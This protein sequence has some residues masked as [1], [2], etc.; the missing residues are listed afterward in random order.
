MG[1][2]GSA[3]FVNI[4]TPDHAG[5][6]AD[7]RNLSIRVPHKSS[8]AR[9]LQYT[10]W[11]TF[12]NC[13]GD[14]E[15]VQRFCMKFKGRTLD[16][17]ELVRNIDPRN[18]QVLTLSME[19]CVQYTGSAL[20]L[21]YDSTQDFSVT[22]LEL[23]IIGLPSG[24]TL[25]HLKQRVPWTS[26][27]AQI[28]ETA[29]LILRSHQTSDSNNTSPDQQLP[30]QNIIGITTDDG[31]SCER[32]FLAIDNSNCNMKL[33][34]F[35]GVDYAPDVKSN[36]RLVLQVQQ[37]SA[38]EDNVTI[39]FL[40]DAQLTMDTM[41]I[42]N[43]TKVQDLKDFIC[44]VYGHT[45]RLA[46]ED[47]KLIYKGHLLHENTLSGDP[48]KAL[49][50]LNERGEV[51]IHV[52][53]NEEYTE[54][55]PGFWNEL[56]SSRDRFSF[57][58]RTVRNERA[59][60]SSIPLQERQD[61]RFSEADAI[62]SSSPQEF[63]TQTGAE[64][65]RTGQFFEKVSIS[66]HESFVQ[67]GFFEPTQTFIELE[68]QKLQLYPEEFVELRGA[69]LLSHRALQRISSNFGIEIQYSEGAESVPAAVT[70][71]AFQNIRATDQLNPV[72][73]EELEEAGRV[74]RLRQWIQTIMRTIYLI[75]RNSVFFFFVFFQFISVLKTR[76]L[77]LGTVLIIMKAIWSTPEIG[78]M[79]RELLSGEEESEISDEELELVTK[80]YTDR[81]LTRAF[82]H[83]FASA[84]PVVGALCRHLSADNQLKVNL[85]N[86]FKLDHT[87]ASILFLARLLEE[88]TSTQHDELDMSNLHE[89]FEPLV[90][91]AVEHAQ[92]P[93]VLDAASKE[94]LK[95]LRKFAYQ[96]S[97]LPWHKNLF[98]LFSSMMDY[99]YNGGLIRRLI[100]VAERRVR[101][102]RLVQR[103]VGDVV[104]LAVL[105]VL[106]LVPRF[107]RQAVLEASL[108]STARSHQD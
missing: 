60:P 108:I 52:Q 64:I 76:H 63:F 105:S 85:A 11:M 75:L 57:M 58:P 101:G 70:S 12:Q 55:G 73:I 62:S 19:H 10:H 26:T 2:T 80:A 15:P 87:D 49:D 97:S 104:K 66:G 27:L 65:Q 79:W 7:R 67:S 42:N 5:H 74:A 18:D 88:C 36:Y 40:S 14:I 20:N 99:I 90:K 45:L 50:Y 68:G 51:K 39:R 35:L 47:I 78:E 34:D 96:R 83:R 71:N 59:M 86:E 8:V 100:P 94:V 24:E 33:S 69:V 61:L 29:A 93:S 98:R 53:I 21:D 25:T 77:I 91:D 81:Q 17:E 32:N 44:S 37:E 16:P 22:N 31:S 84:G 56:L 13:R 23:E 41:T 48:A 107:Q 82:Y 6:G 103:A 38:L 3:I 30:E 72:G 54:P 92:N 1:F 46:R 4:R 95:E 43:E 89:L 28:R 9:L 106:V 102:W